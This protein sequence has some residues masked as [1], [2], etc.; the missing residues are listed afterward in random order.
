[1]IA[2]VTV[3]ACAQVQP[4]PARGGN[5]PNSACQVTD[6]GG[7]DDKS[8]NQTAYQGLIEA[9]DKLNVEQKFLES[10]TPNDFTPNID[11]FI[12]EG[13]DIIITV[14]FLLGGATATAAQQN[15]DQKFAIVDFDFT[16]PNTGKDVKF[17]NVRELVFST[18]QAAFLAGYLAA[19]MTKTKKLGTFG[20][21][22]IP[23]VTVYMSGF[24]AGM[25]LYNKKHHDNVQLLGWNTKSGNGLFT[26]DFENQDNGRRVTE[27]LLEEGADIIMPVAGPVGLGAA[28][29]VQDSG[30][31]HMIWIDTDG[32]VTAPE[33]CSLF[34][35]SVKKNMNV[36]VFDTVKQTINGNYKGGLYVG[37][38]KNK[39]VALA[40]YHD[41]ESSIPAKLKQEIKGLKK[42]I[43]AGKLKT[44]G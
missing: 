17:P 39:G 30:Q 1:M 19:G 41:F 27:S 15:P 26:G 22:N 21:V 20:G 33:Y 14:G 7:I 38:L 35:T 8:F 9:Q 4:L 24:E 12:Q 43:E 6:T 2:A 34:L 42:R 40:P 29:A 37:T 36:A 28:A 44:G 31:G 10:T 32:C 3:A 23:P 11:A 25:N 5:S 13:C 18:D 16:N